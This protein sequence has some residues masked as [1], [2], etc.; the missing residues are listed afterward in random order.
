MN[1]GMQKMQG[2]GVD[3]QQNQRE[4]ELSQKL[5]ALPDT[6]LGYD[7]LQ[8]DMPKG[9]MV[10]GHYIAPSWSQHLANALKMGMGGQIINRRG[11]MAGELAK[12]MA[13]RN[14]MSQGMQGAPGPDADPSGIPY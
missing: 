5:A 12:I 6:D 14:Q 13:E 9:E 1:N 2:F 11:K 4:L 10:S 8:G 7:W 3:P